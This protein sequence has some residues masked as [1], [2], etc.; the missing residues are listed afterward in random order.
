MERISKDILN[1]LSKRLSNGDEQAIELIYKN[2]FHKLLCYGIQVV[3]YQYQNEVEDVI[4]EFFI[5]MAENHSKIGHIRDLESYMFQSIR[6]NVLN[7]LNKNIHDQSSLKK[8]SNLTNPLKDTE[9]CSPEQLQ[10]NKEEIESRSVLIQQE[11]GK[12]PNYQREVLYLRYFEDKSYEEIAEILSVTD[13]VAYNYVYRAIKRLK[14]QLS[15]LIIP[16]LSL[17]SGIMNLFLY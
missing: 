4:Q 14:E 13:Q 3:G 1:R 16:I 2:Y 15:N 7:K 11:L 6:R 5:W 9:E 12:L 8:Y 17:H 10:I